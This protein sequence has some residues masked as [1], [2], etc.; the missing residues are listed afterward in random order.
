M[1]ETCSC[2]FARSSSGNAIKA[3]VTGGKQEG[4]GEQNEVLKHLA[5]VERDNAD[6]QAAR[7]KDRC[8][9]EP[10]ESANGGEQVSQ[11]W[12][13]FLAVRLPAAVTRAPPIPFHLALPSFLH[14]THDRDAENR[15]ESC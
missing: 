15:Q 12:N 8:V 3:M 1:G 2:A 14:I 13:L 5:L 6:K 7:C 10:S 4:K 11:I 9:Y